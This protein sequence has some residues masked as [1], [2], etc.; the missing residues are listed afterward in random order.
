[1]N[2]SPT[3][4][5]SYVELRYLPFDH[6]LRNTLLVDLGAEFKHPQWVEFRPLERGRPLAKNTYNTL[7]GAW[8]DFYEWRVPQQGE[9]A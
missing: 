8:L 7:D 9:P 6:P 5:R 4:N 3:A 2:F 1:M